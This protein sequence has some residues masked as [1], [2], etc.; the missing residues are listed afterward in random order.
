VDRQHALEHASI[1]HSLK[2]LTDFPFIAR[3]VDE[4]RLA[5]HGGWFSIHSGK[6]LWLNDDSGEFEPVEATAP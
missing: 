2:N 6:L 5:L 4:G 1:R 3:A